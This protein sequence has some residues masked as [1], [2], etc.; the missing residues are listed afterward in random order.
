VEL[1]AERREAGCALLGIFH[2]AE[3][4]ERLAS[5]IIDV[6]GFAAMA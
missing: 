3:V 1:I 2:D 6:S 4:R 5:R